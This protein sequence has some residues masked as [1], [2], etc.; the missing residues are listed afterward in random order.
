M[1]QNHP[2]ASVEEERI[3]ETVSTRSY[4]IESVVVYEGGFGPE[5]EKIVVKPYWGPLARGGM[6][7]R[8]KAQLHAPPSRRSK[9][10]QDRTRIETVVEVAGVGKLVLDVDSAG[11]YSLRAYP[12]RSEASS[13]NLLAVGVMHADEIVAIHPERPS[14]AVEG[15]QGAARPEW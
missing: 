11:S 10:L 12:E 2:H 13:R 8:V 9:T 15:E 14:S 7:R 1:R 4:D 3:R 5:A 6:E